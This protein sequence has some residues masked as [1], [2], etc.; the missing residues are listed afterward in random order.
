MRLNAIIGVLLIT[1]GLG[2]LVFQGVNYTTRET[3]IDIGP[4]EATADRQRRLPL[5]PLVG[6]AAVALGA[7]LL[8]G[9]RRKRV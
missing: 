6:V 5:P 8:I 9:G 3:I 7:I 1:L 2:A 4:I